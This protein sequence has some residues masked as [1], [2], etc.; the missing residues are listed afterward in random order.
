MM[1]SRNRQPRRT[2]LERKHGLQCE[3]FTL[4]RVKRFMTVNALAV[5][6]IAVI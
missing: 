5:P 3:V 2:L 4:E 6:G 1:S